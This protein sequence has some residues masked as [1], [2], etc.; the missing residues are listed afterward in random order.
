M[1][2]GANIG[3]TLTSTLV[4]LGYVIKKDQFRKAISAG[5]LHDFFNIFIVI[6]LLPLE[7]YFQ[8]LSGSAAYIATNYFSIDQNFSGELSYGKLFTRPLT[9]AIMSLIP[10]VYLSITLSVLLL[11]LAIKLLS[12]IIYKAFIVEG[13]KK[14]SKKIFKSPLSAFSMGTLI[15]AAVQS[16]T[17][18]TSL[19]VPLV[20]AKK[21]SLSKVF[22][23][24]IGANVGTTITA[25]IAS[26]YKSEA[27]VSIAIAHVLFNL[28]GA[29]LFL[30]FPFLR[31][32]PINLAA[33]FGNMTTKTRFVGFAYILMTF[34]VI[35]FL[36]IYFNRSD[37]S[38]LQTRKKAETFWS[39]PKEERDTK[40]PDFS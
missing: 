3:T 32:I 29:L 37:Q 33:R 15:T 6:I 39:I 28:F 23:F 30:P 34:F 38:R 4:S 13:F 10:N 36:L 2:M 19:I 1:I 9:E 27:A 21:V 17:V 5:I 14:T 25:V 18:T 40:K 22:P 35:P 24:I 20:A 8:A 26:L 31:N 12:G 7:Y 11:F 16:S